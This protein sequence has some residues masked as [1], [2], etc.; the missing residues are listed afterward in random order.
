MHIFLNIGRL[1]IITFYLIA[2]ALLWYAY[3]E[4][5]ASIYGYMGFDRIQNRVKEVEGLLSIL[6]FA[7]LLPSK[8]KKISDFFV[9]VFFLLPVVPML[10]LYSAADQP[11]EYLFFVLLAFSVVCLV[12]MVRLPIIKSVMIP[13]PL[14]MRGLLFLVIIYIL[15]IIWQGGLQYFNL[16]IFKVYEFR[17]FAAQN[18]PKIYAYL[19]PI[20]TKVL[21]PFIL[22]LAVT[23]RRWL[24]VGLAITGSILMFA[25][26]N[27]KGPLFYPIV[28]LSIY[29]IL[30]FKQP[31]LTLMIGY[32]LVIL[33][34]LADFFI[35]DVVN[36]IGSLLFRRVYFVPPNNLFIYYDFFSQHPHTM[37]AQSKLSFGL[38]EYPYDLD[39]SHLI[40]YHYY[41]NVLSGINTGWLGSGYMHFGFGGMFFY[42]LIIGLLLGIVDR[43]ATKRD[44]AICGAVFFIPFFTLFLS[45]DL[46]TS[47]LTHGLV[48]AFFLTWSCKFMVSRRSGR[49]TILAST[50]KLLNCRLNNSRPINV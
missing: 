11:R 40:G 37:L 14:M 49:Y 46:P 7:S 5:I 3:V 44:Y 13:A 15:S 38:I 12:R 36:T 32:I 33:A 17:T 28:V 29:F 43:I 39:S 41:N 30:R 19:S 42:S 8:I 10:V 45:S 35:G 21:L 2:F 47:M 31:L 34:A 48:I 20:V 6:F 27:H 24:V 1:K 4:F 22:L 16:N 23:H 9:H 26:T 50:L 18:L 25:L